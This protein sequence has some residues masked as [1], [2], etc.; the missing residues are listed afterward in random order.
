MLFAQPFPA[1]YVRGNPCHRRKNESECRAP[2]SLS[3]IREVFDSVREMF[4]DDVAYASFE[5][6]D[7]PGALAA[8]RG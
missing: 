3:R 7:G 8:P 4:V 5:R 6:G 2:S 1:L